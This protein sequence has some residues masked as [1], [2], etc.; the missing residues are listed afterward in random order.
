MTTKTTIKRVADKYGESW[1][2]YAHHPRQA[3][4]LYLCCSTKRDAKNAARRLVRF[5]KR[6]DLEILP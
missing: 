3:W 1:L 5:S 2:V 6:D 4:T